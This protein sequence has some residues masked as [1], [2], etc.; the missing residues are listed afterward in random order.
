M[1]RLGGVTP[2]KTTTQ[3]SDFY[4]SQT[5]LDN[6]RPPI[7]PSRKTF[8]GILYA[9]PPI[10]YPLK[11]SKNGPINIMLNASIIWELS[12]CGSSHAWGE[13]RVHTLQLPL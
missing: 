13:W 9:L 10:V 3:C 8:A 12:A 5:C 11:P 4:Y 1:L 6:G 2:C 7:H